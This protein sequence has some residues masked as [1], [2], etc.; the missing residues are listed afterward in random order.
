[1]LSDPA[2][3]DE[4]MLA[5]GSQEERD[6][7]SN[8]WVS[9]KNYSHKSKIQS[10]YNIRLISSDGKE[11][12]GKN[13]LDL[14]KLNAIFEEQKS[15]FKIN[16]SLGMVLRKKTNGELRYWHS[17]YNNGRI[18]DSPMTIQ[19]RQDFDAFL[20]I[21]KNTD[22]HEAVSIDRDTSEWVTQGFTN[23]S[24]YVNHLDFPIQA[25]VKISKCGP[26]KKC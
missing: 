23:M 9:V 8:N 24:I 1:M 5:G 7:L 21:V 3:P 17:S 26:I 4:N 14:D 20:E 13:N 10:T 2:K 6:L 15:A 12:Q 18:L 19:S 16:T 22:Y 25:G 11:W